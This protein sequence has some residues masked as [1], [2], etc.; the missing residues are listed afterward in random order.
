MSGP[1]LRA[2]AIEL[3]GERGWQKKLATALGRDV[4]TVRRFIE[5]D[6]VPVIVALAA[7][8]LQSQN[9]MKPM[10]LPRHKT[11]R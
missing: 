11:E 5:S 6:A 10:P 7:Q 1:E 8:G 4:S 3:Y 2:I 9:A